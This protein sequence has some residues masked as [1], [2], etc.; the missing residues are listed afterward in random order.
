MCQNYNHPEKEGLL[1]Q[2]D[3]EKA[4]DVEFSASNAPHRRRLQSVT[5]TDLNPNRDLT[6]M[7]KVTI[8][9]A[10]IYSQFSYIAIPL[11]YGPPSI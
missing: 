1:L 8:I 4:F 2:L 11:L 5:I 9:K 6:L 10:L 7:G 3:F